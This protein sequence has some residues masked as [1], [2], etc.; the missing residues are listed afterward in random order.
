ML[1]RQLVYCS[2]SNFMA[3]YHVFSAYASQCT[4]NPI[5]SLYYCLDTLSIGNLPFFC[6]CTVRL[7]MR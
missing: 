7:Q 3:W 5:D 2:V 6:I 1:D 4:L